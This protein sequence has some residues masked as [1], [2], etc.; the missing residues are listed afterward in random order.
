[1]SYHYYSVTIILCYHIY[2][3]PCYI[4]TTYNVTIQTSKHIIVE[5][6]Y[7]VAIDV[8][9]SRIDMFALSTNPST[10]EY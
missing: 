5:T 10:V 8:R 3:L 4:G 7:S 1:M 6:Y 9:S 2:E